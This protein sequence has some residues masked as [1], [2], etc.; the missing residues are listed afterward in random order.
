LLL[1]LCR[2]DVGPQHPTARDRTA[3]AFACSNRPARRWP[4]SKPSH[5]GNY[6]HEQW[7]KQIMFKEQLRVELDEGSAGLARY[8]STSDIC[9]L[10]GR[11]AKWLNRNALTLDLPPELTLGER[12]WGRAA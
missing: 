7:R 8:S 6:I 3:T 2:G 5:V 9:R 12:G 10:T 4:F 11:D 1:L